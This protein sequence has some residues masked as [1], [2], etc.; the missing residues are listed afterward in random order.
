M[1]NSVDTEAGGH[2]YGYYQG[3]GILVG[4]G[5]EL[6]RGCVVCRMMGWLPETVPSFPEPVM[7]Y[8]AWQEN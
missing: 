1:E 2:V 4:L 7:C 5:G 8:G 3:V 6:E